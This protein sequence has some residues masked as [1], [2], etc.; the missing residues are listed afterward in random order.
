MSNPINQQQLAWLQEDLKL[1]N[2]TWKDLAYTN[3][4]KK[5]D[6]KF[7]AMTPAERNAENNKRKA[8][9]EAL[10]VLSSKPTVKSSKP[11]ASAKSLIPQGTVMKECK[12]SDVEHSIIRKDGNEVPCKFVHKSQHTLYNMLRPEQKRPENGGRRGRK[13]RRKSR[14]NGGEVK[15]TPSPPPLSSV[16]TYTSWPGG[17]DPTAPLY[18]Q[19]TMLGGKTRRN[20]RR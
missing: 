3:D 7:A 12:S 4:D 14:H 18:N 2:N 8:N 16:N 9:Q 15:I 20:R 10:K 1:F 5:E 6:M 13:S 17:V 19:K 11:T